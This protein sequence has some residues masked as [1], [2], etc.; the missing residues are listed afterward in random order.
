MDLRETYADGR[1]NYR[2]EG[3]APGSYRVLATFDYRAPT[4]QVMDQA[5]AQAIDV[6]EHANREMDLELFGN[7]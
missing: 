3:L 7:R 4:A 1:G 6:T 2:F 5:G